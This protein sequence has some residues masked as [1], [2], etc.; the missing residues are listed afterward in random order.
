MFGNVAI[1]NRIAE[2]ITA[3]DICSPFIGEYSPTDS[4]SVVRQ[5]WDSKLWNTRHES[6][7]D[8]IGLVLKDGAPV[9]TIGYESLEEE[10]SIW[11]T[12]EKLSWKSV[13]AADTPLIETAKLFNEKSPFVFLVLRRNELVGWMSYHHLLG[14]PFRACLFAL[15]LALEQAML[16]VVATNP[17][18]AVGKLRQGRLDGA[19]RVYPQVA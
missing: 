10:R 19:K 9:G 4:G 11:A 13:V 6:P 5:D 15:F 12:M 8:H 1:L 14:I 2:T 17:N 16:D 7:F 3:G 18:V